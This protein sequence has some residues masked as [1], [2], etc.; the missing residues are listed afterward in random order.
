[1]N[2][3]GSQYYAGVTIV[4]ILGVNTPTTLQTLNIG[5]GSNQGS[6]T[7]IFQNRWMPSGERH[8]DT[9]QAYGGAGR[10][11]VAHAVESPRPPSRNR[12]HHL[13]GG[14]QP[15]RSG[16]G[17]HQRRLQ[18]HHIP[19]GQ[20]RPLLPHRP[21][22]PLLAGQVP[23]A[24]QPEPDGRRPLRPQRS[25][26]REVRPLYN[27]DPS[28]FDAGTAGDPTNPAEPSPTTATWSPRTITTLR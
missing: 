22:R 19:A 6:L 15:V 20:R 23:V 5:P 4:D 17:H 10:K 14:L 7:G 26:Q 24:A 25:I 1:V 13:L 11:L 2:N 27:F 18:H 8:L 3:L 16:P 12:R 21:D 9:G 28:L